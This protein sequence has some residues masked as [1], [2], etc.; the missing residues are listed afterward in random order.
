MLLKTF[1]GLSIVA[2][3]GTSPS[4][5]AAQRRRLA[6]LAVLAASGE[7]GVTREKLIGLFWPDTDEARARAALAQ[8]L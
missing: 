7:S 4:G 5:A 2:P 6:L 1:G 3:D 8:A